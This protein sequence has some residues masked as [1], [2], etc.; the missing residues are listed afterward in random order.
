MKVN[1]EG[2]E[3]P[4]AS[5]LQMP[6]EVWETKENRDDIDFESESEPLEEELVIDLQFILMSKKQ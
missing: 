5:S 2:A 6:I 3:A 1:A 4:D